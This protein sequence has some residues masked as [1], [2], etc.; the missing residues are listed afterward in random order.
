MRRLP[1]FRL[2]EPP[3]VT[4]SRARPWHRIFAR[5]SAVGLA[6]LVVYLVAAWIGVHWRHADP[7]RLMLVAERAVT[8]HL[9]AAALQGRRTRSRSNGR[10]YLAV[11]PLQLLPICRS[12]PACPSGT[13]SLCHRARRGR[14]GGVA[15]AAARPRLRRPRHDRVLGRAFTAF[16]TLLFYIAVFGDFYYLAHAESFLH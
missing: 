10:Y 15:G 16:G 1:Y 6:V 7:D 3:S 5:R 11:G 14:P 13:E 12:L 8:G 2:M 9:D 4:P